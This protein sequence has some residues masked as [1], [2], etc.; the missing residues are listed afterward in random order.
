MLIIGAI[1]VLAN[2]ATILDFLGFKKEIKEIKIPA[3]ESTKHDTIIVQT[4]QSLPKAP[5]ESP[6]PQQWGV[7]NPQTTHTTPPQY[8]TPTGFTISV[9]TDRS[10]ATSQA[11]QAGE[12]IRLFVQPTQ[13]CFIRALYKLADGQVVL[14]AEDK[15]VTDK[16]LHTWVELG[17]G[18]EVSEPFGAEELHIFAQSQAFDDL[19]TIEKDGYR[20]VTTGMP[21]AVS[22]T[23]RGLKAKALHTETQL[24]INTK[25]K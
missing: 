14:L 9:K 22:A 25:P 8:E 16:D 7:V 6:K 11:Y 23:R 12:S 5:I 17:A 10:T 24:Y 20:Y 1:A 13:P 2:M 19:K 21:E 4:Q 15:Q 18:F 3:V